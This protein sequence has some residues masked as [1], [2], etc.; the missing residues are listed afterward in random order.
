MVG[1]L[2]GDGLVWATPGL[3]TDTSATAA[4]ARTFARRP[5]GPFKGCKPEGHGERL[6]PLPLMVPPDGRAT[7]R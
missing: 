1:Y 3:P 7:L 4:T 6:K 2:D 5:H